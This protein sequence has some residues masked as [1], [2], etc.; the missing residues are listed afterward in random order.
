[1]PKT[2]EAAWEDARDRITWQNT[3]V[4][5]FAA[6]VKLE[7]V[8]LGAVYRERCQCDDAYRKRHPETH[9]ARFADRIDVIMAGTDTGE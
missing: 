6:L 5:D 7:S 8:R 2:S 3:A 4:R 1:M 9:W